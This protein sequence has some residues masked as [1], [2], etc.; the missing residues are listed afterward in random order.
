MVA[1]SGFPVDQPCDRQVSRAPCMGLSL[2]SEE[3][4]HTLFYPLARSSGLVGGD[5]A[6]EKGGPLPCILAWRLLFAWAAVSGQSPQPAG[7]RR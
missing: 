6:R 2:S 1:H 5:L 4:C 3:S 7:A